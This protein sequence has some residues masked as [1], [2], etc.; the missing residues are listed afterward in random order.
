MVSK[1]ELVGT[2]VMDEV[3]S[4]TLDACWKMLDYRKKG[5]MPKP[6]EEGATGDLNNKGALIIPG[7][8]VPVDSDQKKVSITPYMSSSRSG[9]SKADGMRLC[10]REGLRYDNATLL[11]HDGYAVG[12]NLDNGFFNKMSRQIFTMKTLARKKRNKMPSEQQPD[13]D[14]S[15]VSISQC[16]RFMKN[17]NG[18]KTKISSVI[19][20]CLTERE[21]YH[22]A[23]A[24]SFGIT[25]DIKND[26]F[27]KSIRS[28]EEPIKDDSN[29]ILAAPYVIAC[30]T[31]RYREEA[32]AGIIRILGIGEFGEF[33][34]ITFERATNTL[35]QEVDG[36]RDAYNPDEIFLEHGDTKLVGVLRYY[37]KTT[38]GKR[39]ARESTLLLSHKKD[40]SIDLEEIAGEAQER[41]KILS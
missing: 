28:T 11:Y 23:F 33:A 39:K 12:V 34:N 6:E 35:L 31:T 37:P 4:V 16:P 2:V 8:I 7:G 40:L 10:I 18:S 5:I 26:P 25:F 14:S 41:Y 24:Y 19:G 15:M 22:K 29:N 36:V 3:I 27:Y 30:H 1:K 9:F 13:I 32:Y 21:L 20:A 38:P 17:V